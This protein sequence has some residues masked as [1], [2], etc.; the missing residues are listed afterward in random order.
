MR[1]GVASA[2]VTAFAINRINER[3]RFPDGAGV[4]VLNRDNSVRW[5]SEIS[6]GFGVQVMV[7][8]ATSNVLVSFAMSNHSSITWALGLTSTAVATFGTVEGIR[9]VDTMGAIRSDGSR[10]LYAYREGWPAN[11]L[12]ESTSRDVYTWDGADYEF[13]GCEVVEA[14]GAVGG[15]RVLQVIPAHE[16]GCQRPIGR[17]SLDL[18][19]S[20]TTGP[21]P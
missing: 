5:R 2:G 7:T 6:T 19:G 20:R 12:N 21:P 10:P 13:A 16:A 18:P 15:V 17:Y 14:G 11:T 8:D 4:V 9:P 1:I 3:T